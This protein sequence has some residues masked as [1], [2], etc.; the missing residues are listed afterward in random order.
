MTGDPIVSP[1]GAELFFLGT[2]ARTAQGY[3]GNFPSMSSFGRQ[4]EEL[5]KVASGMAMHK[6]WRKT[7]FST[8]SSMAHEAYTFWTGERFQQRASPPR[9]IRRWTCPTARPAGPVL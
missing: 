4:F 2:N 8:P 3:H 6:K 9:S 7:Y 1:N 5:N